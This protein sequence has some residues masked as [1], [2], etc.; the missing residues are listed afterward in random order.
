MAAPVRE[1]SAN[2]SRELESVVIWPAIALVSGWGLLLLAVPLVL[3][4]VA[5]ARTAPPKVEA[6]APGIEPSGQMTFR[7][8]MPGSRTEPREAT[9]LPAGPVKA[10]PETPRPLTP[11]A[12]VVKRPPAKTAKAS[13]AK[14]L[15]PAHV[16]SAGPLLPPVPAPGPVKPPEKNAAAAPGFKRVSGHS[17]YQ[18]LQL[19]NEAAREIDL[20]TDKRTS[21]KLLR[22]AEKARLETADAKATND[23]DPPRPLPKSQPVLELIAHRDDLRGLPVLNG[24]DCRTGEKEARILE[25]L[26]REARRGLAR[27]TRTQN[28]QGSLSAKQRNEDMIHVMKDLKPRKGANDD[29]TTRMVLQIFQAAEAPVRLEMVKKLSALKGDR[30]SAALARMATFDL[31]AEVREAA[32]KALKD[33]P[34]KE[35]RALLLRGL[36]YPWAPAAEHAAEALVALDDRT[37]VFDL[38]GLLD[39]PDPVAPVRAKD[40]KW[41]RP[42]LVRVNHLGNCLLCHAPSFSE[43]DPIRGL[44]P[45]RGK[46]LP[47][48]AYYESRRGMFVRADVTYLRQDFSIVQFVPNPDKWP[49]VQRFDYLVR[50]RELTEH[51]VLRLVRPDAK[52][53]SYPQR[54][55]VVWALRELT[56]A[57]PGDRT[58]DWCDLVLWQW[59]AGDL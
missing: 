11:R 32:V 19:L 43:K 2:R 22:E 56:G 6:P 24:P 52:P 54:Q 26:S 50:Q 30:A 18:L 27:R 35:Y 15:G 45:E 9:P 20:E 39:L 25:E 48:E 28:G 4:L 17:D 38:V 14:D 40:K 57:D 58:K 29:A 21:T 33:R 3:G 13:P 53:A 59:L 41:T 7:L 5:W 37:A 47:T 46:P 12:V 31:A 55:A 44:V 34:A 36:R 49:Y 1:P 23:K 51:E 42:E 8:T 10:A 16:A